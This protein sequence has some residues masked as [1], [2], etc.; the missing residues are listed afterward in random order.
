M[1]L[2]HS[3]RR[4]KKKFHIVFFDLKSAF[5]M[6]HHATLFERLESLQVNPV[7]IRVIS[8]MYSD[9]T[10]KLKIADGIA[11]KA[12]PIRNGVRQGCPLS[13]LLFSL[14]IDPIATILKEAFCS[15]TY[16]KDEMI[17]NLLYCD[18]LVIFG[19]NP[20]ELQKGLD[21]V[22]EFCQSN[23]LQINLQK[24]KV[25][26][27]D[28]HTKP[29]QKLLLQGQIIESVQ[30][31]KY[32]GFHM[33]TKGN[34][35]TQAMEINKQCGHPIFFLRKLSAY[36]AIKYK[37]LVQFLTAM[38][39][40]IVLYASEAWG[41]FM[42]WNLGPW[43]RSL[44]ERV[45]FRCCKSILQVSPTTDSIGARSEVG[46]L[47]L[48]YNIQKRSLRYWASV[49]KRP[50]SVI[51][52][53]IDDPAY[54]DIGISAK[55]KSSTMDNCSFVNVTKA[56]KTHKLNFERQFIEY[57]RQRVNNSSK[58]NH[59]YYTF[60]ITYSTEKYLVVID[61]PT[62]RKTLATFRLGNCKLACETLRTARP[63]IPYEDRT[64][65][66]CQ[67][68]VESEVHFLFKCDWNRYNKIRECFVAEM[69][70]K[71]SEFQ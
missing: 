11:T 61:D 66:V 60:K 70:K 45:N 13:P 71:S 52:K 4:S 9:A 43:D 18:D 2:I 26:H 28:T 39:D 44:F 65:P 17:N 53:L 55:M 8:S 3:K 23:K 62:Y 19:E 12:H 42:T 37:Q 54:S 1:S 67:T 32:L 49:S 20:I 27:C 29:Q 6:V 63:K 46:R 59:F 48:L 47:P 22:S 7:L 14:Y 16:I 21:K 36:K 31:Y 25:L 41:A 24:T 68:E 64:C 58:L 10:F 30:T 56:I 40:S 15:N 50:D 5:D 33:N 57:W 38:I 51:A 34:V 69:S 35:D